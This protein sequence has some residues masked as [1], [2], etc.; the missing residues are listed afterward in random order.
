M[1]IVLTV[2]IHNRRQFLAALG[3]SSTVFVGGCFES[4]PS[5]ET[6]DD[7][8]ADEN[9]TNG[10][11]EPEEVDV[12]RIAANPTD[13]PDPVDWDEPREH[14]LT[15]ESIEAVAEIEPGVTLRY[16]TYERQ[17]PGPMIRVREG[18]TIDLTFEVPED[19]N[20]DA[21]NVDFHAVY[22]PG[23]GAAD[24]TLAPGDESVNI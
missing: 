12:D 13:V 5:A 24:T 7:A 19:E 23:G 16:M 9:A 17:I 1:S 22:G 15:L 18:D 4:S 8:Q 3:A 21:H 11:L 20:A 14:E 6:A 10:L 2:N